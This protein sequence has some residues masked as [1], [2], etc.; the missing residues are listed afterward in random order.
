M[1]DAR[2]RLRLG[3][4]GVGWIGMHRMRA[5]HDTGC[6][7][8]VGIA[9]PSPEM[10]AAAVEMAPEAVSVDC[11][12][13][14]LDLGIDGLVIATP[15]ALHAAQACQALN[16]G[17]AVF[18]QKP[19]GRTAAEVSAVVEAARRANLLLGV[20]MSY[21]ATAGMGLIRDRVR[22]GEFGRIYAADLMFHNAYGP[23]K[24]WFYDPMLS[25]GGC[26]MDLGVHL[27]D[28]ALWTLDWPAVT[29]LAAKL[30]VK[31][32]PLGP[33]TDRVEDFAIASIGLGTGAFIRIA[34]SWRL[35]AGQ[36]AVISAHFHGTEG[37]AAMRNLG[38]S[39]YDFAA[40]TYQGT[41]QQVIASPP[42]DWGSRT[43]AQWATN[44]AQGNRFDAETLRL[45]DVADA[46]D[47]LYGR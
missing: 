39:F 9:D 43:A 21:R 1:P 14:L 15:S 27:I 19:L 16:R 10:A 38:G 40:E 36:D 24:A 22:R 26:L 30:F 29:E 17:V 42:D 37:G 35:H 18:C 41:A 47:R 31:G 23:D 4:L 13:A 44:L 45:I 46:L 8:I 11:I 34:C 20:D 5:I 33:E 2:R 3:F 7:K 12:D 28:L 32:K 6:V 25:G